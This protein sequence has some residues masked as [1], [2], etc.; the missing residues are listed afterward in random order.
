MSFA[1]SLLGCP[2][3]ETQPNNQQSN[4]KLHKDVNGIS[5]KDD[6]HYRSLVGQLNY[7]T[8]LTRPEIQYAVHQCARFSDDPK[9]SHEVAAKRIVRY[10]KSTPDEGIILKPDKLKD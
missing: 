3:G 5:R 1:S 10:L 8:Q 4:V 2:L 7:L 6:F 9:H